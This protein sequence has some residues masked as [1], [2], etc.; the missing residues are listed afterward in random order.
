MKRLIL[1]DPI[2]VLVL[3]LGFGFLFAIT[4]IPTAKEDNNGIT[5]GVIGFMGVVLNWRYG[6]SKGSAKKDDTIQ[7]ALNDKNPVVN[8]AETVN[9][10]QTS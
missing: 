4:F 2:A 1:E 3:I 5:I 10:K 9:V 8:S 7:T 6:S